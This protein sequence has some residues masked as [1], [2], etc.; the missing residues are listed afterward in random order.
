MKRTR[1]P[2]MNCRVTAPGFVSRSL[3]VSTNLPSQPGNSENASPA[4]SRTLGCGGTARWPHCAQNGPPS[5]AW[6][7]RQWVAQSGRAS[8][9]AARGS[10]PLD[11]GGR[12]GADVVD[13]T[14]DPAHLVDD[15]IGDTRQHVVREG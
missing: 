12:L 13:D 7:F 6:Q 5:A 9:G 3:N 2:S 8:T 15:S 14:I 11:G 10:L 1:R 4:S